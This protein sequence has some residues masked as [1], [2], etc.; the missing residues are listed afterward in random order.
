MTLYHQPHLA[1]RIET[2]RG[3]VYG[4]HGYTDRERE[5]DRSEARHGT[6]THPHTGS[7][8]HTHLEGA[9]SRCSGTTGITVHTPHE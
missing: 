3:Q 4:A 6:H 1:L 2:E 8:T 7:H 5:R 9:D